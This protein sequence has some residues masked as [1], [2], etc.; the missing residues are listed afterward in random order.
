MKKASAKKHRR[1]S[2]A[3]QVNIL[4]ILITLSISILMVV[5]NISNYHRAILDP[6]KRK[7][8]ELEIEED[9]LTPYLEYFARFFGTEEMRN[10]R[11]SINT[12][13]DYFVDWM[14][15]FPSCTDD[16]PEKGAEN[17]LMDTVAF[18]LIIG[19]SMDSID[20]DLA[21]GEI[22]KD[23]V[24]YR[25]SYNQ[26]KDGGFSALDEFGKEEAFFDHPDRFIMCRLFVRM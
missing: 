1:P 4:I 6:F 21:C 15:Q 18:D 8:A 2:L 26:K 20:L 19:E 5:I 14:E 11:A 23:G 17:L 25:V 9:T 12:A 3:V 24:V 22:L 7:L 13:D 10:A 16:D